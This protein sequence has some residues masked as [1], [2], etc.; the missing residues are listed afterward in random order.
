MKRE[1]NKVR[2][3]YRLEM[4]SRFF[5]GTGYAYGLTDRTVQK[6]GEGYLVIP[7]STLKGII[8]ENCEKVVQLAEGQ[9]PDPH[10]EKSAMY[11]FTSPGV[12]EDIFGSRFQEGT[13]YFDPARL[14]E[15]YKA[16]FDGESEKKRYLASQVQLMTQ[17]SLDRRTGTAKKQALFTSEFGPG[18]LVF[19]GEILGS[20][21]GYSLGEVEPGRAGTDSLLLL[22][23]GLY[24]VERVGGDGSRGAGKCLLEVES[25][26]V[27]GEEADPPGYLDL[28][29]D[30]GL[31]LVERG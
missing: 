1:K 28:L 10:G 4:L 26:T 3:G 18:G 11:A 24:L 6:D 22:L 30:L 7:G 16:L 27:D 2:I 20:L 9:A 12:I 8:R 14:G 17:A 21:G 31:Y 13:L 5:C 29:G 23:A 25:L 15:D 19:Q